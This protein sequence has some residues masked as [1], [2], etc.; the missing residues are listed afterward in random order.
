[1]EKTYDGT[2]IYES[3]DK[4]RTVYARPFGQLSPRF[5]IKGPA[6]QAEKSAH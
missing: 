2:M 4:G 3:P 6:K 1:M 5:L